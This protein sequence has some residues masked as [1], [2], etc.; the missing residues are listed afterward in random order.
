[1]RQQV[2]Y[3]RQTRNNAIITGVVNT[4]WKL[5]HFIFERTALGEEDKQNELVSNFLIGSS[6]F[7]KIIQYFQQSTSPESRVKM[8][9]TLRKDERKGKEK[10]EKSI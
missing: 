10:E 7:L 6:S 5:I 4:I 8:L 1:M 2:N 3:R 9:E